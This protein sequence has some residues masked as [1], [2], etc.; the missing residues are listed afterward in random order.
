MTLLEIAGIELFSGANFSQA[1]YFS[2]Q[3][4]SEPHSSEPQFE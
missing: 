3:T 1:D 4:L 2:Q